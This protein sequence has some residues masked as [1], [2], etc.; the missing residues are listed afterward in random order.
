MDTG[1]ILHPI[2]LDPASSVRVERVVRRAGSAPPL[3]L[4]HFHEA[5]ELIWFRRAD[6]EI[7]TEYGVFPVRAG[8]LLFLPSMVAHDLRL[9]AGA[10]S[11][12]LVHLD[13]AIAQEIA[14]TPRWHCLPPGIARAQVTAAFARLQELAARPEQSGDMVA[15]T[16]LLLKGLP[17]PENRADLA[18][19][20]LAL[21]R[22]R[23]AL[24]LVA[25][26]NDRLVTI[27]DAAACCSLSTSRF[28]Q[29]FSK[30]FRTPFAEYARQYRLQAAARSLITSELAVSA[31]AQQSGFPNPSHF[32]S[33]FLKRFG[34]SPSHFRRFYQART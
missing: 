26:A 12:V 21:K 1:T 32:S 10:T 23:P 20:G 6:G 5:A 11:W 19:A 18:Y 4:P 8:T 24:E 16:K 17:Q 34:V 29:A 33:A 13:P 9:S 15:L 22:L 3:S 30:A 7:S 27:E 31:I 14:V 2:T 28:S 25:E